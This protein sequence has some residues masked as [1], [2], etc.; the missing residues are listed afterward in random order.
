MRLHQERPSRQSQSASTHT[1]VVDPDV[2]RPSTA[3]AMSSPANQSE[4]RERQRGARREPQT[5]VRSKQSA[6]VSLDGGIEGW[7]DFDA[8]QLLAEPDDNNSASDV[9]DI[10]TPLNAY[11]EAMDKARPASQRVKSRKSARYSAPPSAAPSTMSSHPD[12][13]SKRSRTAQ[14][15][16]AVDMTR[17]TTEVLRQ[18]K[19]EVMEFD[20]QLDHSSA[21]ARKRAV[22]LS[23][24]HR[25]SQSNQQQQQTDSADSCL[26]LIA[27]RSAV[28]ENHDV[29]PKLDPQISSDEP[30]SEVVRDHLLRLWLAMASSSSTAP[31]SPVEQQA[32]STFECSMTVLKLCKTVGISLDSV[33][34]TTMAFWRR[35]DR[36]NEQYVEFDEFFEF[37]SRAIIHPALH[38]FKLDHSVDDYVATVNSIVANLIEEPG[39]TMAE[40]ASR[41][42]CVKKVKELGEVHA[43]LPFW[44]LGISNEEASR[45][46]PVPDRA[47]RC[48]DIPA[49]RSSPDEAIKQ[50]QWDHEEANGE[51]QPTLIP[52]S[53]DQHRVVKR[54]APGQLIGEA[55][56]AHVHN[57]QRTMQLRSS[58]KL[59]PALSNQRAHPVSVASSVSST[60]I[61]YRRAEREGKGAGEASAAGLAV[62]AD[63]GVS[64]P[65]Q[66]P[67]R[68]HE[69]PPVASG[70][71]VGQNPTPLKEE[72]EEPE[73][74]ELLCSACSLATALLWC[75]SCFSVLCEPCWQEIHHSKVDMTHLH[76]LSGAGAPLC[77]T[78]LPLRMKSENHTH[79][80]PPSV[81]MVYLPTKAMS[82]VRAPIRGG[83]GV[84]SV[85]NH[86]RVMTE[87]TPVLADLR[88][89]AMDMGIDTHAI[90]PTVLPSVKSSRGAK[91]R[92]SQ[93]IDEGVSIA[94]LAKALMLGAGPR[95][96]DQH[97]DQQG[98]GS[99]S[100]PTLSLPSAPSP[101][102]T[103]SSS[104][105]S[106]SGAPGASLK[107]LQ[108]KHRLRPTLRSSAVVLDAS[109]LLPHNGA[110]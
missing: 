33:G 74:R 10:G 82:P 86:R 105:A 92:H 53:M 93:S 68:P 85:H 1:K 52:L 29:E 55:K 7:G 14:S 78:V 100:T 72:K 12:E 95:H 99:T 57:I 109:Q 49:A 24:K 41:G 104:T 61:E 71:H 62:D 81:P 45:K 58:W 102:S 21:H 46:R 20:L 34:P 5:L 91:L 101:W 6:R 26:P 13:E 17:P 94:E 84:A 2:H 83:G 88:T 64:K 48:E 106:L 98:T 107:A 77:P 70:D 89:K 44:K 28:P 30:T 65:I 43:L 69:L 110:R 80:V 4:K 19:L 16:S 47:A 37:V 9:N 59:K 38:H 50:R 23:G 73:Q 96:G 63:A 97:H 18:R 31:S 36:S 22:L 25:R 66:L 67:G 35:G 27:Q 8:D 15:H 11:L 32:K 108:L 40:R 76:S 54:V 60:L 90:L 103:T 51:V 39:A 79:G 75:S 42:D 87:G 56:D 3:A